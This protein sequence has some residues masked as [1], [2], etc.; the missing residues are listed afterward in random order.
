MQGGRTL[1]GADA[2]GDDLRGVKGYL[3][4]RLYDVPVGTVC[5]GCKART[6]SFADNLV[7]GLEAAGRADEAE[8]YGRLVGTLLRE[9]GS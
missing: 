5:E 6:V 1:W 7:R 9:T 3:E 2:S 4:D 8:E